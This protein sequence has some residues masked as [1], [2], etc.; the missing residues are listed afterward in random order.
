MAIAKVEPPNF[1]TA[2]GWASD[3]GARIAAD[4]ET[5]HWQVVAV[6]REEMLHDSTQ[7]FYA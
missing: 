3:D 1:D 6:E 4:V 7:F 2:V 5:E